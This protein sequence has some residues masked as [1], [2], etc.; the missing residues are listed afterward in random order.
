[1]NIALTGAKGFIGKIITKELWDRGAYV[2]ACRTDTLEFPKPTIDCLIHCARHHE[3][4]TPPI[5]PEKWAR[6]YET[7]VVLPWYFTE[8]M[9]KLNP[10]LNNIIIVTSIYGIKPPTV[11][12]IPE[13]YCM[14]KAAEN[15]MVKMMAVKYAPKIRVNGLILGG[16]ESDREVAEQTDE[17]RYKY[18]SK[19]LVRRMVK[20][21]EVADAILTLTRYSNGMTGSYIN[22]TG[23]YGLD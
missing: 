20:P 5:T 8:E 12:W 19:T 23:G 16:V 11:R 1:M 6:E 15:F 4:I 17:F 10:D 21:E 13:N 3:Y 2:I 18:S 9:V 7:D 14:A 22:L